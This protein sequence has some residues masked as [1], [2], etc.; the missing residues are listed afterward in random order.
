MFKCTI[1]IEAAEDCEYVPRCHQ[2]DGVQMIEK[3]SVMFNL[4]KV[5]EETRGAKVLPVDEGTGEPE[6][7]GFV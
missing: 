1:Q 3:E 7:D 6:V 4:G 5:S 2:A